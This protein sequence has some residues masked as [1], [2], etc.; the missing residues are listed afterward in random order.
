M[1]LKNLPPLPDIPEHDQT[2][3]VKTLLAFI[4]QLAEQVQQQA[5]EIARLKDEINILK[6][7]K[8]RPTFKPSKLDKKTDA[9]T[10]SDKSAGKRP[11]SNKRT[12]TRELSIHEDVVITPDNKTLTGQLPSELS[13]RHLGSQRVNP[14]TNITTARQ[15]SL[16]C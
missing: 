12:E 7:E 3:L 14:C 16:Y 4:E 11:D 5:E 1:C 13:Q 6:G 15:R 9:K 2:S 10:T 8:K